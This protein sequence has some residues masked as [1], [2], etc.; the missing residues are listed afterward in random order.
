MT[1]ARPTDATTVNLLEAFTNPPP[2]KFPTHL[3]SG[4]GLSFCYAGLSHGEVLRRLEVTDDQDDD[5][6]SDHSDDSRMG[7]R[8]YS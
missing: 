7:N 1:A 3:N 2:G 8:V 4:P 5:S 6:D